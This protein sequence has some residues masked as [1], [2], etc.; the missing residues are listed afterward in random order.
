LD[1]INRDDKK[2]IYKGKDLTFLSEWDSLLNI[3][4]LIME[5]RKILLTIEAPNSLE[6]ER[7]TIVYYSDES[8]YENET[9]DN[10]LEQLV[11]SINLKK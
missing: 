8:M 2:L 11:S 9:L 1:E 6:N 4:D 5:E 3:Y 10:L 7:N